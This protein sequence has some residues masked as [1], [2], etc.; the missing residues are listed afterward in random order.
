MDFEHNGTM[1][2]SAPEKVGGDCQDCAFQND[3]IGCKESTRYLKC[4]PSRV[5]WVKKEPEVKVQDTP[6]DK[7]TEL[8]F[9]DRLCELL[10]EEA[11][12]NRKIN[13]IYVRERTVDG[14]PLTLEIDYEYIK[15]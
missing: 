10:R 11:L 4:A 9:E 1:Y 15:A 8:T 2:T 14:K 6:K 7:T 13:S 5:I 12:K 3:S